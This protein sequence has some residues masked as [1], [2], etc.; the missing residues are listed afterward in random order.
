MH[1]RVSSVVVRRNILAMKGKRMRT[2]ATHRTIS[3]FH[4]SVEGW[5]MYIQHLKFYFTANDVTQAE[6]WRPILPACC[7]TAT[8][9][10]IRS[11]VARNKPTEVPYQK[12][13]DFVQTRYNPRPSLIIQ[14]FRTGQDLRFGG[15]TPCRP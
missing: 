6:K 15:E 3:E 11:L 10:L 7:G 9:G 8:Y 2:M 4:G 12:L 1:E 14:G 5:I 13:V